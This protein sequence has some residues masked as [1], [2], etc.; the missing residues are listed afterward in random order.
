[1]MDDPEYVRKAMSRIDEFEE[2]G[3]RLGENLIYTW[4]TKSQPLNPHVIRKKINKY[5]K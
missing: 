3:I 2:N 5:L 4:E 1:M